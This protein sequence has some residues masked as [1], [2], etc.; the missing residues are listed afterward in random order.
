MKVKWS[1][2]GPLV[3]LAVC[4]IGAYIKWQQVKRDEQREE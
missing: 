2:L 1:E 4:V 3:L